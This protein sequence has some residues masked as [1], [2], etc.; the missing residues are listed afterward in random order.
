MTFYDI[1]SDRPEKRTCFI[2]CVQKRFYKPS[3]A[4]DKP[5]LPCILTASWVCFY[6]DFPFIVVSFHLPGPVFIQHLPPV[7]S[8]RKHTNQKGFWFL[9]E[10][11][12]LNIAFPGAFQ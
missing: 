8:F 1:K 3:S 10:I 6:P 7:I 12:Y 9:H 4:H 5:M 11:R 2:G